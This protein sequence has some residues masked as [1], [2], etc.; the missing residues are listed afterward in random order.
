VEPDKPKVICIGRIL[1][2]NLASTVDSLPPPHKA[3]Q[4]MNS[5]KCPGGSAANT[6]LGINSLGTPVTILGTIGDDIDGKNLSSSL[7]DAGIKLELTI[8]EK[9]PTSYCSVYI[10]KNGIA[11]Y[12][13]YLGADS[14]VKFSDLITGRSK[15]LIEHKGLR[16]V[17]LGGMNLL[18]N[19]EGKYLKKLFSELKKINPQITISVDTSKVPDNEFKNRVALEYCDILF[20]T[21]DEAYEMTRKF[22][23][24]GIIKTL[25]AC[26]PEIII[27]KLGNKGSC[28][29]S[30]GFDELHIIQTYD[31]QNKVVNLNGAGDVFASVFIHHLASSNK[32]LQDITIDQLIYWCEDATD[33][34]VEFLL[35]DDLSIIKDLRKYTY[36]PDKIATKTETNEKTIILP[37][38]Y[39]FETSD[40]NK[41]S[42][43]DATIPTESQIEV[44]ETINKRL[45]NDFKIIDLCC[46]GAWLPIRL[47]MIKDKNYRIILC[48]K[49]KHQVDIAELNVKRHLNPG[50]YKVEYHCC[51]AITSSLPPDESDFIIISFAIHLFD[52]TQKIELAQECAR[53][54]KKGG[55][56]GILTFDPVD[57]KQTIFHTYI[58]NYLEIDS[59]RYVDPA[60]IIFNFEEHGFSLKSKQKFQYSRIFNN[61]NDF[62]KHARSKPFSTFYLLEEKYGI[63]GLNQRL[64]KCEQNLFNHFDEN[65]VENKSAVTLII[66]TL[67]GK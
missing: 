43:E 3:K 46:G 42:L 23:I 50:F 16:H 57:I 37:I 39:C 30:S 22:T 63:D 8:L 58:D 51:D 34:T 62:M 7:L 48:D 10:G 13:Y 40:Y 5:V 14:K 55:M 15:L 45:S 36:A 27:L 20:I 64:D 11:R 2:D 31:V 60:K 24:E 25:S 21:E 52:N 28:L 59:K 38:V 18:P 67:E 4:I 12:F 66:L 65:K 33:Y 26:G 49:F 53:L 41:N 6:A 44:T 61:V 56:L 17:H 29:Y 1:L 19:L 47:A 9:E 35:R 32:N 54:L